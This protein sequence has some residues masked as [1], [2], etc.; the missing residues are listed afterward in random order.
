MKNEKTADIFLTP[1]EAGDLLRVKLTTVYRWVQIRKIP[2]RK[3][4]RILRFEKNSLLEWSKRTEIKPFSE[5]A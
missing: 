3:H 4:G 5:E 1:L 2:F